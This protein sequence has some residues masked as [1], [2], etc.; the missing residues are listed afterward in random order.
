[1]GSVT[2]LDPLLPANDAGTPHFD[3]L[4]I[5]GGFGGCYSLYKFR[6][7]GFKT[8]IIEAGAALGGVWHW[9]SY[10][11]ARVD[12]EV[13]YYQFSIPEVWRSW[14]WTQRFPDHHEI[15]RYFA[16]V[17]RV[18]DLS[19]DVTFQ[20]VVVGAT[21]D[22]ARSR[23][24]VDTDKGG[25]FT[26]TYLVPATGSSY[27]RYE[28]DFKNMGLFQG[29]IAHSASWPQSG[30]A[31]RGKRVAVVGAGATGV[32]LVQEISKVAG[33]LTVYVRS[34]NLALPMGQRDLSE[35]EAES[36]KAIYKSLFQ[37]AR[38]TSAGVAGD[39]QTLRAAD[40]DQAQREQLWGELWRRGGFNFLAFNYADTMLDAATNRM[41]YDFWA[42]KTREKIRD[43]VKRDL[44]APL[45]PPYVFGTK[46]NSLE[47][48]YYD[49]LNQDHVRVVD[50]RA[51][52]IRAFNAAGIVTDDGQARAHD[53]VVLATGYDNVT[54]SLTR[55][56][57]RDTDGVDIRERWKDGVRT[58]LG[59][60]TSGYPNLFMI[61]GPQAPTGLTNAPVFIEGQVDLVAGFVAKLRTEGIARIEATKAAEARWGETVRDLNNQT[62]FRYSTSWYVGA[63]IPGKKREPLN[64][65]GG[66]PA[67]NAAVANSFKDWTDFHIVRA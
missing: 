28:P 16:H 45:E 56:G 49:C 19:K 54:G 46:R 6:N 3:V 40:H 41:V 38:Q 31:L 57:L 11:G 42:K 48:D 7:L 35:L 13:P 26:C 60:M 4:V 24:T 37:L 23:W 12:S 27:K 17:D 51:A 67:Y 25:R 36:A 39:A 1:M 64:Y 32:Q 63:N 8:H 9:N 53:V 65:V 5:G 66:I 18:L 34:P 33:E 14:T 61:Y 30:V 59:I 2:L 29:R 58:H 55:M 20:T 10:P 21:F 15:K 43:P 52:P 44:L 22:A 47:Q 62:L 50:V